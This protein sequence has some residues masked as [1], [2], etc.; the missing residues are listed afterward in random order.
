MN[1]LTSARN[2]FA[3][4]RTQASSDDP[5][6]AG[7]SAQARLFD[8]VAVDDLVR[9]LTR[10]P[11][12]DEVL[13]QAGIRRTHL[14]VLIYDDEIA[15]ACDTRRD[16]LLGVPIRLEPSEGQPAE[17]LMEMLAPLLTDAI[18][19]AFQARLYGYSVLEAVY[20]PRPDGFVGL[21][22]LGEKPFE[23][24][25]P[26][27]DGRLQFFPAAGTNNPEGETVDQEFKFFLTRAGA[28]Y[29]NPYGT[30]LL[31][32]LYWPWFFRQNGWKFWAK[33]LERFGAPLLVGKSSDPA[34][35]VNALL[36]AHSQA[37]MGIDRD[38]SVEAVGSAAGNTGEAF[39]RFEV[40][41]LRRIQKVVLGQTLTSGTD[42]G[43]GNRALGQVHDSVRIDK[44]NSDIALVRPT[45]QR[46]VDAL[47]KLNRWPPHVVVFSDEV[48]LETDRAVRDKDL[49]QVG[50][51]FE[52]SYFEDNYD[53]RAE[54]FNLASEAMGAGQ[55][56]TT[57]SSLDG[58]TKPGSP[59]AAT[60][61]PKAGASAEASK[62]LPRLFTRAKD[63]QAGFTPAQQI[64]ERVGAFALAQG[65][66]PIPSDLLR[67]AV[68]KATSPE[69]L[70]ERLFALVGDRV[71]SEQ[72][73]ETLEAA[74]YTA[75]VLGY[76]HAEK[77][78]S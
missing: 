40:S 78:L 73:T 62:G 74:I 28:T 63:G 13:K 29:Q 72:F 70:E 77:N 66:V 17:I 25:E 7:S 21:R 16:A 60:V 9:M 15:Q 37:V 50:V 35:M 8:E 20:A 32:R 49:Y 19:G 48:G 30:A 57:E 45:I 58:D 61:A 22:F 24:F 23:W 43:S 18:T 4:S 39:D 71:S 6:K 12:L 14:R 10:V 76:V 52:K 42:G 44:R 47:C 5:T 34:A 54:D 2:L 38:D 53:L 69:D 67:S 1:I 59:G 26:K 11:D 51:R 68:L 55:S 27:S 64:V 41:I 56:P 33:F 31:S 3:K 46:I 65:A 75:D 36:M